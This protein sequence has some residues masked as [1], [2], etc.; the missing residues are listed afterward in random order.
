LVLGDAVRA[1]AS[2]TLASSENPLFM[3]PPVTPIVKSTRCW[4]REQ[5]HSG[6]SQAGRPALTMHIKSDSDEQ[7]KGRVMDV[8]RLRT[9]IVVRRRMSY[10]R[11][12]LNAQP[13]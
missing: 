6:G 1:N 12:L 7:P 3:A 13:L 4:G 8:R 10:V 11:E 5:W 9:S 2:D